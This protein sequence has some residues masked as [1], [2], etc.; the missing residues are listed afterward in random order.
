MQGVREPVARV[1][2]WESYFMTLESSPLYHPLCTG[3]TACAPVLYC[4][5]VLQVQLEKLTA[6]FASTVTPEVKHK[7]T[8]PGESMQVGSWFSLGVRAPPY[9]TN[10]PI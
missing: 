4:M 8:Q 7:L 5:L 6:E 10:L 3:W 9:T 2:F 1:R